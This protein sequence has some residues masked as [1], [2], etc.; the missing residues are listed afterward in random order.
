MRVKEI[1]FINKDSTILVILNDL[2]L[3]GVEQSYTVYVNGK[4]LKKLERVSICM[5][6]KQMNHLD[7]TVIQTRTCLEELQ[8]IDLR[9]EV[10]ELR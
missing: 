2:V 5:I 9:K 10:V 4:V 6:S 1:F 8:D 3:E 7:N